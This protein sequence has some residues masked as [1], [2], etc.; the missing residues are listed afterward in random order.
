MSAEAGTPGLA[1][2]QVRARNGAA[3]SENKIHDNEVARQYGFAGGLVPG[4]TI[5][6]YMTRPALERFG[7]DWLSRGTISARFVKPFYEGEL[8]TV[9]TRDAGAGRIELEAVNEAGEVCATGAASLPETPGE[10]PALLREESLP[11]RKA[12][13]PASEAAF[14]R[15]PALGTLRFAFD[16]GAPAAVFLDEIADTHPLYRGPGAPAH[17]GYLIRYANTVLVENVELGPWIHVSSDSRHFGTIGHGESFSVRAA[18]TGLFERKGHRF[19][20]L[21]VQVVAGA[22][23]VVLS[24]VHT[25]IYDIRKV[26]AS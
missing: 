19:V 26:A 16:T 6:A 10:A 5:Y 23:R 12:R 17:P 9:R 20:T 4:V 14:R 11:P 2:Y 8:V 3:A 1:P 15:T 25:A 18:V 7:P 13:P 22:T 21:D 24:T